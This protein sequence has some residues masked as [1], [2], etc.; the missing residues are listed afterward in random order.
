MP[1]IE[2]LRKKSVEQA[3]EA[4][5][6]LDHAA[7]TKEDKEQAA[8]LLKEIEDRKGAIEQLE[9]L[10]AA[11]GYLAQSQGRATDSDLEDGAGG[12]REPRVTQAEVR[13]LIRQPDGTYQDGRVIN[14]KEEFRTLG[15]QLMAVRRASQPGGSVDP[16]LQ[17]VN[18]RAEEE[19]A[20]SGMGESVGSDGGFVVQ[21]D[22]ANELALRTY[23]TGEI[24]TRVRRIPVSA[25]ANGL[26]MN[27][28]NETSRA[29]G[30]RWGGIRVY[31]TA[32]A[33]A[34]TG[35]KPAFRQMELALKKLT[36]LLYATDELMQDAA[37]LDAVI[38]EA[39]PKEMS[40]VMEDEIINGTGAGQMLGVLNSAALVSVAKETGQGA[41]TVQKE[42]IDKMWARAYAPGRGSMVWLINQDIEPQLDN[43]SLVIGTGGVPV[44]L[45]PGGLSETPFARLKGRQVI[46]VEYC[47]TLG[48]VGDILLV[49]LSQYIM[50]DK[51]GMQ[52]TMSIHVRF[53][54]D[55][56]TFRF[57]MRND[58][59]PAWNSALTPFKGTTT[60]SP[61]VALATRA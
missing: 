30:S 39:F 14:P 8:T 10:A 38:N 27:V 17:A 47:A 43:M 34:L 9:R 59:Q 3:A 29:N 49:D 26:K 50:I 24:L 44:Y 37:A 22:F 40:F 35:T 51:G 45:P 32:E 55:E 20:A 41:A 58:G 33:G 19:R 57:I 42:N 6:L 48:T 12:R 13:T 61:Y 31:R 36:G 4:R 11:E 52:A 54:N 21:Q 23:S 5:K 15:E 28:I 18:R 16:R 60:L 2:D 56:S 7:P 46:P 25:N 53:L 1:K